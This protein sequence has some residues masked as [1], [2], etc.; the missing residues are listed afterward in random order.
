MELTLTTPAL[1]FSTIS[2][3]LLAY[4]NRF[5]AIANLV[6]GLHTQ[7]KANRDEKIMG[8]MNNLR[9]RIRL[10]RDMQ[11]VGVLSLFFCVLCMFLLFT[12]HIT[13]ANFVFGTS[14]FLLMWSL[15]LSTYENYIS[16][17]ALSIQLSD[18]EGE[19]T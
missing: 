12:K 10:V 7:Y 14:L 17:T 18:L 8:Q 2:L 3:L 16:T 6:R 15:A 11:T 1:L 19:A 9:T 4:T 5:L 13:T